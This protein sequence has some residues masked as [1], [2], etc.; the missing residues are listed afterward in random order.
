MIA[1]RLAA[2]LASCVLGGLLLVPAAGATPSAAAGYTVK[3]VCAAPAPGHASCLGLRLVPP[4]ASAAATPSARGGTARGGAASPAHATPPKAGLSPAALHKAY[5]LPLE[6]PEPQTIAI[7]DAY[8]DPNIEADLGVFDGQYGLPPCNGCFTKVN[9]QDLSSPLPAGN[10]EWSIEIATDVEVARSICQNCHILLVEATTASFPDLE[11]AEETAAARIAAASKPGALEGEIS[12]S[13]GGSEPSEPP[14]EGPA[15]NHP[16]IPITASAGDA[17]YLNW[18][19]SE[20]SAEEGYFAGPDYPASSRH[21]IAVGGTSL[22]LNAS[23]EWEGE[24]VWNDTAGA[25]GGGCSKVLAAPSWQAQVSDWASVGCGSQRAVADVAADG[26]PYTGVDVYDSTPEGLG[27]PEKPEGEAPK[28]IQIGGT[29]VASPIIASIFALAGGAHGVAY[30]AATLYYHA[31]SGEAASNG[32][33]DIVA[34]GNGECGGVYSGGCS[35]SLASPLDCGALASICNAAPGYDGPTGVGTPNGLAAFQPPPAGG[36]GNPGGTG[37]S[38]GSGSGSGGASSGGSG[39]GAGSGS[40]S[41]GESAGGGQ[42]PPGTAKPGAASGPV[43]LTRLS[44]TLS[45]VVALNRGRAPLSRI[46]FTFALSRAATVRVTLARR[47]RVHGHW[48]WSALRGADTISGR[49]GSNRARLSGRGVLSA[50]LYRLTL[51]PAGGTAR[52]LP[53]SIG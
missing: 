20:K 30:P 16:G 15:F 42:S 40:G 2:A 21:V 14:F 5:V 12:N 9:Q 13:W 46:A 39:A 36:S 43:R 17:G 4:P 25:G 38:G 22:A 6:S 45:A 23:G 11:A 48:R 24:S 19:E 47:V 18:Q 28:W 3:A 7:V 10:G 52:S 37:G 27:I 29:S 49:A 34:G 44:L 33:H 50:G 32:L 26:D 41:S 8:D 35:G 53:I 1:S 31:S 51:T